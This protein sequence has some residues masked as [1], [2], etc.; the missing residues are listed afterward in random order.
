MRTHTKHAAHRHTYYT[1]Y[2]ENLVVCE[3]INVSLFSTQKE[4]KKTDEKYRKKNN[5]RYKYAA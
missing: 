5:D 2:I 4:K 3:N 1:Y